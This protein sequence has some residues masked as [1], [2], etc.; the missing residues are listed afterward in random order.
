MNQIKIWSRV[1]G[2][3]KQKDNIERPKLLFQKGRRAVF[4]PVPDL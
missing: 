1:S 4:V 2:D 3:R